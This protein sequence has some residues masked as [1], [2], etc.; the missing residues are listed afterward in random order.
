[1]KTPLLTIIMVIALIVV[2]GQ[3]IKKACKTGHHAWCVPEST[4]H[5]AKARA[6]V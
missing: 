1:M 4:W 3:T 6:P 5:H 2:G